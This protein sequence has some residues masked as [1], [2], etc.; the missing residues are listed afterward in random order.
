MKRRRPDRNGD[1]D[2]VAVFDELYE[3]TFAQVLAYCRRR[4]RSLEDAEDAVVETFLVAWRKLDDAT[5][6]DSPLL[7]L[8]GVASRVIGNQRRGQDRFG[9][10]IGKIGRLFDRR[11]VPGPDEQVLTAAEATQVAAALETLS[12]IDRELIRL[13]AYEQLS[14]TEAGVVVGLSESAIRSRLFRVR[15]RLRRHLDAIRRD[16][17]DLPDTGTDEAPTRRPGDSQGEQP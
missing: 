11:G 6:A 1:P 17:P 5:S 12:G 9:R 8:Y 2:P 3:A 4:T 15:R 16:D 14:Y 13:V 10:L 7:W